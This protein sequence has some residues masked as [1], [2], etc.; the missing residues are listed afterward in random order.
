MS[1]STLTK[2][3]KFLL[4]TVCF[5]STGVSFSQT[6]C[7]SGNWMGATVINASQYPYTSPGTGITVTATLGGGITTLNNFVYTCNGTAYNCTNPAWWMNNAGQSIT[8][9][10]SAPV[11]SFSVIVNGTNNCE[12]FYFNT[13][14][15][16]PNCLQV[17]ALCNTNWTSING[18]TGLLYTGA[19]ATSNLIVVN[20]PPG[21]TQYILTH[22]GCGAGSRYA[23]VDCWVP[24]TVSPSLVIGMSQ[25]NATCGGCDGNITATPSGPP[26]PYTYAWAPSGGNAATASNLCPGTY[27]VTVSAQGGCITNTATATIIGNVSTAINTPSQTNV[28][29]NGGSNGSATANPSG[30]TGP[31][32]YAWAPSGGTGS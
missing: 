2:I 1:Y 17:S 26:G 12:Q 6:A 10:F 29:C 16:Q 30:G 7:T 5:T 21:A 8:L 31:Y 14:V 11:S 4:V 22:N 27:T 13:G 19:P 25:N 9:N 24:A 18:G 3:I 23:L 28:S 20:N 32:T 15:G